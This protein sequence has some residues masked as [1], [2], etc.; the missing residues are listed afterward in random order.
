MQIGD[1]W[2]GWGKDIGQALKVKEVKI[3]FWEN[4]EYQKNSD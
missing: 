4:R 3:S 1:F 2:G